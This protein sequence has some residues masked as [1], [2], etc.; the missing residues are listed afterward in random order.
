MLGP[1]SEP[2]ELVFGAYLFFRCHRISQSWEK[3]IF[4][5]FK[6]VFHVISPD[7]KQQSWKFQDFI[8]E[9]KGMVW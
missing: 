8:L 7:L 5:Q 6:A 4:G 2:T 1:P 3:L 9:K